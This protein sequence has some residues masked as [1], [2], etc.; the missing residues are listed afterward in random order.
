M[1]KEIIINIDNIGFS[2]VSE[3]APKQK[4]WDERFEE[5]NLLKAEHGKVDV[6]TKDADK[7]KLGTW[8]NRQHQGYIKY[9]LGKTQN[10][11]YGMCDDRRI[12]NLESIG[13][14]LES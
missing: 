2:W 6:S 5:L 1:C 7:P 3:A 14:E 4:T 12:K 11:C 10:S 8:V 9:K 13:F